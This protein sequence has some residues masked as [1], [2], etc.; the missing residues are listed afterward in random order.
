MHI[1]THGYITFQ[2]QYSYL[3]NVHTNISS[4]VLTLFCVLCPILPVSLDYSFIHS[5]LLFH[6]FS[7]TFIQYYNYWS[8]IFIKSLQGIIK[9]KKNLK[10]QKW[11]IRSHKIEEHKKSKDKQWSTKHRK[12]TIQQR[13]DHYKA[14][15]RK[16]NDSATCGSLQNTS[17]K[18]NDSATCG[19]LQNSQ[20]YDLQLTSYA[21]SSY[22]RKICE[23]DSSHW[24][25]IIDTTL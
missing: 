14:L 15:V 17:Q 3:L 11:V 24:L 7:L 9:Y 21:I 5:C 13:V 4:F 10:I 23:L 16:G 2:I 6:R 1:Y 22:R 8:S 20:I 25:Y 12:V 18:S 19:S